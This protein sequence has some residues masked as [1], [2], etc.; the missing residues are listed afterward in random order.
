MADVSKS[1]GVGDTVYVWFKDSNTLNK[2]PNQRVVA[3]VRTLDASNT[4][5]VTF[6]TGEK[7]I[8]GASTAKRVYDTQ[9]ACAAAIVDAVITDFTPCVLLDTGTTSGSSTSGQVATTLVRKN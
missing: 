9:A 3:D 4:A 8:D 5:E 7:I 6:T 2:L 1:Y